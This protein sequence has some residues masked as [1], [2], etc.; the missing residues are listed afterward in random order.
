M[1]QTLLRAILGTVAVALVIANQALAASVCS[2]VFELR[3]TEKITPSQIAQ[4]LQSIAR[5][6]L[7]VDLSKS[8][9]TNSIV[10]FKEKLLRKKYLELVTSLSGTLSEKEIKARITQEIAV[11]Q[12]GG[13][14][15]DIADKDARTAQKRQ[16]LYITP[17]ELK[18]AF[19]MKRKSLIEA[20][21]FV[22]AMEYV[23]K[24]DSLLMLTES[25]S[26]HHDRLISLLNLKTQEETNLWKTDSTAL[27]KTKFSSTRKFLGALSTAKNEKG[28]LYFYDIESAAGKLIPFPENIQ[29]KPNDEV[30]ALDISPSGS[31]ALLVLA[32]SVNGQKRAYILDTHTGLASYHAELSEYA[33]KKHGDWET[34]F[35]SESELLILSEQ[36][37]GTYDL[38]SHK[39]VSEIFYGQRFYSMTISLELD[40]VFLTMS[41]SGARE[42]PTFKTAHRENINGESRWALRTENMPESIG[43]MKTLPKGGIFI[44]KKMMNAQNEIMTFKPGE[45][46]RLALTLLEPGDP[47]PFANLAIDSSGRRIFIFTEGNDGDRFLQIW[48]KDAEK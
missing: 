16:E 44:R 25:S 43:S 11:L 39:S 24:L 23:P 34:Q 40:Q 35:L 26:D 38:H 12:E 9:Q 47:K 31:S 19:P 27:K 42:A 4:A 10:Q 14:K 1:K 22:D 28:E 36:T 33:Q 8:A 32:D 15:K 7:E 20:Y 30:I 37:L 2:Q 18:N 3:P 45:D 17:F 6:S 48:G 46:L 41:Y 5:F 21:T 13:R 29:Y